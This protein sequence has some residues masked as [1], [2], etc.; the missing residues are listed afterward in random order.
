MQQVH[1]NRLGVNSIEFESDDVEMPLSPGEERSFELVMINYGAPT[2]V[3]VSVSESI[4]ENVTILEDNPYVRHEEYLPLIVRIPYDGRLYN[5]GKVF[6]TVGY[7]SRKEGF[8]VNIGLP[9]PNEANF[10]VDIDK[11]LSS[12]KTN[13]SY[14]SSYKEDN[15]S[16][17][18]PEIS[19][20]ML[21]SAFETAASR[22]GH[23]VISII[24]VL[25]VLALAFFLSS[26]DF[27][28]LFGFYH[29]VFL[30]IIL[31]G[32]MAYLLIKLPIFK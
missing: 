6:V 29:A 30:S 7:G 18:L 17:Q 20:Q 22:S 26:L 3:N 13:A 25:F 15:W 8:N 23:L 32:F 14:N 12:P 28:V 24:A 5:K 16:T 4:A 31:T 9:G 10:S 2:H 11:S 1:I 21:I 27:S 19:L